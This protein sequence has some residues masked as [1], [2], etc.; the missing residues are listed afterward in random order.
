MKY[1]CVPVILLSQLQIG[2]DNISQA[3]DDDRYLFINFF[4]A[5]DMVIK[6]RWYKIK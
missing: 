4:Y 2:E 1:T 5:A 3:E 6:S